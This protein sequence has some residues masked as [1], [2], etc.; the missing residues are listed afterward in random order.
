MPFGAEDPIEEIPL[1]AIQGVLGGE[2]RVTARGEECR[3]RAEE[4]FPHRLA[5]VVVPCAEEGGDVAR[6]ELV[7]GGGFLHIATHG[8]EADPWKGQTLQVVRRGAGVHITGKQNGGRLLECNKDPLNPGGGPLDRPAA[9]KPVRATGE[10]L[11]GR[12]AE[13]VAR[14]R[15]TVHFA[16][17]DPI[18]VFAFQRK[19][20]LGSGD[21]TDFGDPQIEE[22]RRAGEGAEDVDDHR[23]AAGLPRALLQAQ[24]AHIHDALLD[25]ARDSVSGGASMISISG[26]GRRT[27]GEAVAERAS[28]K[29]RPPASSSGVI[30]RR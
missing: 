25:S 12:V 20:L 4:E 8:D 1:Q 23:G 13:V 11:L 14:D 19:A 24:E 15:R 6:A 30:A 5:V 22:Q 28:A 18:G 27:P 21:E 29:R 10:N 3:H 2:I 16:D 17:E 26:F 9:P 7:L